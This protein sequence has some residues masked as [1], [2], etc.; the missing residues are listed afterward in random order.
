MQS[1][2]GSLVVSAATSRTANA[3][4]DHLRRVLHHTSPDTASL[5]LSIGS[6]LPQIIHANSVK[7]RVSRRMEEDPAMSTSQQML[8]YKFAGLFH[9]RCSAIRRWKD[10]ITCFGTIASPFSPAASMASFHRLAQRHHLHP[11]VNPAARRLFPLL[12]VKSKNSS[13]S[14]PATEWLPVSSGPT[15]QYPS[16]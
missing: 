7:R 10:G 1:R 16:R 9:A 11:A 5:V 15:R 13:D 14:T 2:N 3:G 4:I 12:A 6:V 8:P